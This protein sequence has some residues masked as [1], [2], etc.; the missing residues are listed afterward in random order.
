MDNR[1]VYNPRRKPKKEITMEYYK[2]LELDDIEYID[3]LKDRSK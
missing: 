3:D 2:N 1:R